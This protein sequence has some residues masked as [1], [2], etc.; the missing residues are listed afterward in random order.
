MSRPFH[1]SPGVVVSVEEADELYRIIGAVLGA[2]MVAGAGRAGVAVAVTD[3]ALKD[4]SSARAVGARPQAATRWNVVV[5]RR[6]AQRGDGREPDPA[7][8]DTSGRVIMPR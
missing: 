5:P 3:P 2:A 4:A 6:P 1:R 8:P 7:F